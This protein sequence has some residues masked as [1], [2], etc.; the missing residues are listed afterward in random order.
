MLYKFY[1]ISIYLVILDS[2]LTGDDKTVPKNW[3]RKIKKKKLKICVIWGITHS[4]MTG[5]A[6]ASYCGARH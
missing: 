2:F 1:F 5:P 3:A 4:T 6:Q